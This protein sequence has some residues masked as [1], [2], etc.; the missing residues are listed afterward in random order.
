MINPCMS[1]G[2]DR[3][4]PA[5]E[6]CGQASGHAPDPA[7]PKEYD[8]TRDAQPPVMDVFRVALQEV[9]RIVGNAYTLDQT[10]TARVRG[11]VLAALQGAP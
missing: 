1:C 10:E 8:P 9:D 5:P 7:E 11:I 2:E 4:S 3:R 6:R